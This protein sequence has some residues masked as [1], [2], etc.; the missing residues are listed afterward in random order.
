MFR[1]GTFTF[2][3]NRFE[4]RRD[5]VVIAFI[6]MVERR[7]YSF[8]LFSLL[9]ILYEHVEIHGFVTNS[10]FMYRVLSLT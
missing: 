5:Y 10:S 7:M 6:F 1:G 9:L 8:I 2:I 3:V 4:E